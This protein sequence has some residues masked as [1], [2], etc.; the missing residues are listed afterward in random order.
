VTRDRAGG[1]RESEPEAAERL[2]EETSDGIVT[3]D[4]EWRITSLN[5]AAEKINGV[6]RD[7]VV[8]TVFW[9]RFPGAVGTDIERRFRRA[10]ETR[11]KVRF[12]AFYPPGRRWFQFRVRPA[13]GGGLRMLQRDVTARK[14][15]EERLERRR[16]ELEAVLASMPDAV[17]IGDERGIT[18]CNRLG[19]EMLGYGSAS[20]LE[21]ELGQLGEEVDIR[22][23]ETRERVPAADTAFSRAL[24]GET[25]D[26]NVRVRNVR[27]GREM[28]LRSAA[29]PIRE[30]GRIVGAVAI[31]T[32]ITDRY[33]AQE[34]LRLSEER[35]RL[36][37]ESLRDYAIFTM[38][39]EG[40]VTGWN[41][42]AERL[43]G[44]KE[45]EILGRSASFVFLESDVREGVPA[46]EMSA[47]LR[48]GRSVN[49]RWHRRRDGSRLWGSGLVMPIL[50]PSGRLVGF[51]KIMQDRT[52]SR[53]NEERLQ[54][55]KEEAESAN[56]A[57][58]QFLATLS[59]ELRTPLT[60]V[61]GAVT[62]FQSRTDVPGDLRQALEMIRR[63]VELEAR[64]IDDL[65][66]VTRIARGK[67]EVARERVD[68]RQVVG[69]ALQ[70][71]LAQQ[72]RPKRLAIERRGGDAELPVIGDVARLTQVFWN[73]LNNAVKFTSPG[74]RVTIDA[75]RRGDEIVVE[76]AD[77]GI[78]IPGSRLGSIFDAFEQGSPAITRTF[79]GLGLG[80]AISRTIVEAHSGRLTAESE[81]PGKGARFTVTLP[82]ASAEAAAARPAAGREPDAEARRALHVLLVEDHRDSAAALATLLELLGHRVEIAGS[83]LEAEQA[84]GASIA[85]SNPFDLVISDL[86]LPDGSGLALMREL[87]LH[88]GLKGL[89]LS[90]F[91]MEED[92]RQSLAAGFAAHLTKPVNLR[93]LNDA[94]EE[95][96]ARPDER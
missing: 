70:T 83:V 58:D 89:A 76:I 60:P 74:G 25:V 50:H 51:A 27:T 93:R 53:L 5:P 41:V 44:W 45:E 71:S 30:G 63:N 32:D 4:A 67:L 13:E 48:E 11:E 2:F 28:I 82:A 78:G 15:S 20:E 12:E 43:F 66:D 33:R 47:A 54:A 52:E 94:I 81:G 84:A 31:N 64:L 69:D 34:D 85:N 62:A 80:L 38:D 75:G 1:T 10:A 65:L 59:H 92:V 6:R 87:S 91:A 73:L 18:Q 96:M 7:E 35:F 24:R 57:K 14:Q 23:A 86:G 16:A 68:L 49:E 37:V 26:M 29:A 72:A 22:Y 21:R 90:G 77:T 19:W 17:Y 8:G 3:F 40:K 55:A 39:P 9:E 46:R 56:R 79:G 95:L 88:Y 36:L 42:G 61:L